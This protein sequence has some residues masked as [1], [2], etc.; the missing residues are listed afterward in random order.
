M[1]PFNQREKDRNATCIIRMAG[2]HGKTTIIN[3]DTS[4]EKDFAF[5]YSYWSHDGFDTLSSPEPDLHLPGDGYNA[6][7][8]RRGGAS[9]SQYGFE[10]ADQRFVYEGLGRGVLNNA[11]DGFNCCLFAYGQT[12]SGKSYSFVGYGSNKGIVPQVRQATHDQLHHRWRVGARPAVPPV[13]C[14]RACGG[15]GTRAPP[16][17]RLSPVPYAVRATAP[18]LLVFDVAAACA[19]IGV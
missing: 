16:S 17:D 2:A 8:N 14:V 5:D 12:G 11:L 10:Y 6:P 18:T 13:S 4:E 19:W 1:R 9:T 3:P 15:G 7:A